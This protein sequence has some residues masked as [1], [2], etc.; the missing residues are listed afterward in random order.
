MEVV[1]CR[2]E[3]HNDPIQKSFTNSLMFNPI[4]KGRY[5][6]LNSRQKGLLDFKWEDVSMF[7]FL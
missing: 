6:E 1:K 5:R 3:G 2:G 7:T 4:M